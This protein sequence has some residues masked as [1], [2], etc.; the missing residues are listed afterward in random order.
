MILPSRDRVR[1]D[2]GPRLPCP[3]LPEKGRVPASIIDPIDL[4][5]V[6]AQFRF[7]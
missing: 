4:T 1:T 6:S 5:Y 3:C 7:A 2:S